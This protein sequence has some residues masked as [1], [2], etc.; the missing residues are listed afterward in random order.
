MK[1]YIRAAA[2]VLLACSLPLAAA[3]FSFT[4]VSPQVVSPRISGMGGFHAA[5]VI[6]YDTMFSNPAGLARTGD[7][8]MLGALS[9]NVSGPIFELPG[10]IS[11][12]KDIVDALLD[13]V[14]KNNGLS[15][16]A[17]VT[18]PIAFG[19]IKN[20]IGFG[21]FNRTFGSGDIPSVSKSHIYAGEEI[22]LVGGY[23]FDIIRTD[24]HRL[25]AG[26]T[27]KGFFQTQGIFDKAP[28]ALASLDFA[29]LPLVMTTGFGM[30]AGLLYTFSDWLNVGVAY[31]N[32]YTPTF[33]MKYDSY[34]KFLDLKTDYN[35]LMKTVPSDLAVGVGIN[36]PVGW[37]HGV[38]SEWSV[39]ID[40]K[41]I[42][43][44]FSPMSR[45]QLLNLTAGTEMILFDVLA[46]RCG[47]Q[48]MYF[49]AG[50]GVSLK[51]S[52]ST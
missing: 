7:C 38:I 46:L 1:R 11:S 49:A 20:N 34:R 41:D 31:R 51:R 6:G 26:F 52:S 8:K 43:G 30:D 18:G 10:M 2:F 14:S 29:Q 21:I 28:T 32:I 17:D 3:D 47:V 25:S 16:G 50:A 22:L 35:M 40:Y 42:V 13:V 39:M 5:A 24:E 48:D 4:P 9:A 37:S 36:I 44:S 12:N 19:L 15:L 27:I 23:G 33:N 45:N